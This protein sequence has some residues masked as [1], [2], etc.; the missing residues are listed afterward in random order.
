MMNITE[1][2]FRSGMGTTIDIDDK[3]FTTSA[4]AVLVTQLHLG[5][6]SFV[7]STFYSESMWLNLH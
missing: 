6:N 1:I 4:G 5:E 2:T 3:T 7:I